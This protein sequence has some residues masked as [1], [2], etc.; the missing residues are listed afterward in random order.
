MVVGKRVLLSLAVLCLDTVF[1]GQLIRDVNE[2]VPL[3]ANSS[4]SITVPTT[5]RVPPKVPPIGV[6]TKPA[7]VAI[8]ETIALD[9]TSTEYDAGVKQPDTQA[10]PATTT[11][12]RAVGLV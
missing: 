6:Q 1:G 4:T 8:T 3:E 11:P 5:T 10:A 9:T 7:V 12:T 2:V